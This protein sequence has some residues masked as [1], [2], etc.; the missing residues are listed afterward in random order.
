MKYITTII[1]LLFCLSSFG[2]TNSNRFEF[3]WNAFT[4]SPRTIFCKNWP[5]NQTIS[6]LRHYKHSDTLTL[7]GIGN[8]STYKALFKIGLKKNSITGIRQL[9]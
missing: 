7:F 9:K 4:D 1:A 8:D 2:Q 3:H 5:E 6:E